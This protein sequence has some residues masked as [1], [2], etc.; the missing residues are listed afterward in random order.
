MLLYNPI[1]SL[2]L[3]VKLVDSPN[4][5]KGILSDIPLGGGM[6]LVLSFFIGIILSKIIFTETA[7][8]YS[9][10]YVGIIVMFVSGTIDDAYD[11]RPIAKF[12]IQF[13]LSIVTIISSDLLLIDFNGL[14]G[15]EELP[16]YLAWPFTIIYFLFFINMF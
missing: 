2:Y 3:S 10:M 6:S 5:R 11:M 12:F 7:E 4:R 13:I 14:F 15:I 9:V 8:L 1:R 16:L